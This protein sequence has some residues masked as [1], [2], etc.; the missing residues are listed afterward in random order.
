MRIF[1][2]S[3]NRGAAGRILLLIPVLLIALLLK[4]HYSAASPADLRWILTPTAW[5]V[6][7][8]SGIP[9]SFEAGVGY[10]SADRLWTIAKSCAGVNFLIVAFGM[11]ATLFVLK[12]R[13]WFHQAGMIAI[14]FALSYGAT[15]SVNTLRI[16]VSIKLY[17]ADIYGG[18]LTPEG[19]HRVAGVIVY[20][21]GLLIVYRSARKF[22]VEKKSECGSIK[23]DQPRTFSLTAGACAIPL[24]WYLTM[25]VAIP[26]V[27]GVRSVDFWNH[28]VWVAG[29][30]MTIFGLI[31]MIGFCIN[32]NRASGKGVRS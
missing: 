28:S 3:V 29:T 11:T 18:W 10:A 32:K 5:L 15:I 30:A 27:N 26:Y 4:R 13:P 1:L 2:P 14:A 22:T 31:A 16:C 12:I 23:P 7:L 24:F 25:T 9:F 20:F 6:H 19:V 21:A 17:G 8:V